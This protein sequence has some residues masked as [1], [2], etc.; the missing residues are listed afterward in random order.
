MKTSHSKGL[1]NGR[2]SS[3]FGKAAGQMLCWR[4]LSQSYKADISALYELVGDHYRCIKDF[5]L[6]FQVRNV[7]V[8][9][10]N[11]VQEKKN[12]FLYHETQNISELYYTYWF[13][14]AN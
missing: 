13:A 7:S 3:V 14:R 6:Q 4:N 11:A 9:G 10:E 5:H 1:M 12:V 8:Y 2:Q